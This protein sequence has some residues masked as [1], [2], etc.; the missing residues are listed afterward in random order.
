MKARK[1][2]FELAERF[3]VPIRSSLYALLVEGTVSMTEKLYNRAYP[4]QILHMHRLNG[5][6]SCIIEDA[7]HARWRFKKW[8]SRFVQTNH[9]VVKC[10]SNCFDLRCEAILIIY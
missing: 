5:M 9:H 6:A 8:I 1:N 3:G 7:I 2:C 10:A 4:R